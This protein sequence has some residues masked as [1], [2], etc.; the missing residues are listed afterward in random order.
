MLSL[1]MSAAMWRGVRELEPLMSG[2]EWPCISTACNMEKKKTDRQRVKTWPPVRFSIGSSLDV[3][4]LLLQLWN[5]MWNYQQFPSTF[6]DL[7]SY[8]YFKISYLVFWSLWR[9]TLTILSSPALTAVCSGESWFS[10]NIVTSALAANS[11]STIPT[12]LLMIALCRGVRPE[13]SKAFTSDGEKS[14]WNVVRDQEQST[15]QRQMKASEVYC[16]PRRLRCM[17]GMYMLLLW[18]LL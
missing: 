13:S 1:F 9:H 14:E 7:S 17:F 4:V 12:W 3:C 2:S 8:F 11:I 6:K 10:S 16:A 5:F 18:K 15:A